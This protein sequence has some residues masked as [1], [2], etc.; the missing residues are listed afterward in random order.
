[1]MIK[2]GLSAIMPAHVVY[3]A[4]DAELPA[5]YSKIW[6]KDVLRDQLD[7]KGLIF[8][9]SLTMEGACGVGDIVKRVA[10]SQ[11]AGCD[12]FLICNRPDLVDLVLADS[13]NLEL[14]DYTDSW[15]MMRDTRSSKSYQQTMSTDEFQ[16]AQKIVSGL[17]QESDLIN[18]VEVGEA[19]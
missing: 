14:R 7:F 19:N 9:D 6:L 1:E 12:I 11:Q 2:K 17:Y 15:S 18:G 13:D 16:Q 4:V 8:S 3:S 10:L 5:G